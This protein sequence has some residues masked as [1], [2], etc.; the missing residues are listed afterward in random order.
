[1][2]VS[3]L[4]YAT[5]ANANNNNDSLLYDVSA[6]LDDD[7]TGNVNNQPHRLSSSADNKS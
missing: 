3:I 7:D 1:M 2:K 4:I 6:I 5:N